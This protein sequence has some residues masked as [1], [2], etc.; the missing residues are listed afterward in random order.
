MTK[1]KLVK[2]EGKQNLLMYMLYIVHVWMCYVAIK[3]NTSE[4]NIFEWITLNA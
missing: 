2:Q 3:R 1:Y 4:S